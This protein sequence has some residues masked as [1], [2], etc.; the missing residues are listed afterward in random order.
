MQTSAALERKRAAVLAEARQ[1]LAGRSAED[2]HRFERAL[3]RAERAYPVREDHEFYLS[4]SA[5]V[6]RCVSARSAARRRTF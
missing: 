5:A 1:L 2:C 6:V 3:A 4:N